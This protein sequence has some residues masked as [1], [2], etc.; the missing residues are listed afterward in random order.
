MVMLNLR[1]TIINTLLYTECVIEK[2]STL[3]NV[4]VELHNICLARVTLSCYERICFANLTQNWWHVQILKPGCSKFISS[5]YIIIPIIHC[6]QKAWFKALNNGSGSSHCVQST[7]GQAYI[8]R[9]LNVLKID[10]ETKFFSSCS[11]NI[12]GAQNCTAGYLRTDVA[13][14]L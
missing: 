10:I 8:A 6:L 3:F 1:I 4:I 12:N 14:T 5:Q 11:Y 13:P 2:Q 9:V 7:S